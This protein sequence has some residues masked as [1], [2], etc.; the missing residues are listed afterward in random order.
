MLDP[1]EVDVETH[2]AVQ[3]AELPDAVRQVDALLP[4]PR[5]GELPVG[6]GGGPVEVKVPG[7]IRFELWSKLRLCLEKIGLRLRE[8]N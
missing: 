1:L 4:R 2:A 3:P 7:L 5:L 8:L 6:N